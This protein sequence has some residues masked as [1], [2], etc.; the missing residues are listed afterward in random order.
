[1]ISSAERVKAILNKIKSNSYLLSEYEKANITIEV[2]AETFI[3]IKPI[4]FVDGEPAEQTDRKDKMHQELIKE[5]FEY[6]K[7]EAINDQFNEWKI[8][9]EGYYPSF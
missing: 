8:L 3:T 9:P 2:G 5:G 6:R 7:A 4:L 1:M